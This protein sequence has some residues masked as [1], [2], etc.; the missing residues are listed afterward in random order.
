LY[1]ILRH[2]TWRAKGVLHA[3]SYPLLCSC[4]SSASQSAP[5]SLEDVLRDFLL[6][7]LLGLRLIKSKRVTV[8][9]CSIRELNENCFVILTGKL[10]TA[11]RGGVGDNLEN[12]PDVLAYQ[13][14]VG[15]TV[16]EVAE[17]NALP[18]DFWVLWWWWS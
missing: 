16:C 6:L 7:L 12:E 2:F 18:Q 11:R 5:F 9:L 4:Q 3:H 15:A 10:R 17:S 1:E 13:T 8:L 14:G